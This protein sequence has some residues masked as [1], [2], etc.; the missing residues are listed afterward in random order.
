[1]VAA[2]IHLSV[3]FATSQEDATITDPAARHHLEDT[4]VAK[5]IAIVEAEIAVQAGI[6]IAHVH[7][8]ED[9]GII[10]V[11]ALAEEASMKKKRSQSPDVTPEMCLTSKLF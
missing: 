5:G 2:A 8:T 6:E 11:Q 1:M 3:T 4:V 9:Q 7:L 10:G